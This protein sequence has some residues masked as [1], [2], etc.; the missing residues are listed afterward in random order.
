MIPD[1]IGPYSIER[2][3]GAGGMGTVY[4]GKRDGDGLVAAIKVLPAS[5]A[6]EEGFVARF[7]REI[8]AL[9]KLKNPHVVELYESGVH[10]ETYYYSMEYV[11]GETLTKIL[12]REGRLKWEQVVDYGVQIC[13]ALKA[14]HDAGIV[15][16]DLKPSNLM[17][18]QE[19]QIK[20]MDFGVAYFFAATKLTATRASIGTAEFMSPEQASGSRVTKQSDL[21]SLGAV[22]YAMVTGRP[23]FDGKSSLD[24]MRKHQ[25]ALF[26]H[27][28]KV[29]PE[30]PH[31]LDAVIVQCL[32][33][34]PEK[35]YPDAYVLSLRLAEIPRKMELSRQDVT[36]VGAGSG[37]GEAA[38][39]VH[40]QPAEQLGGGTLMRDLMKAEIEHMHEK[41]PLQKVLDNTFVLVTILV[42]LV[43]GT[44]YFL[45][46]RGQSADHLLNRGL[47]L[48]S[49]GTSQWSK[50]GEQYLEPWLAENPEAAPEQIAKAETALKTI[51]AYQFRKNF[52]F[53]RPSLRLDAPQNEWE[54]LL[55]EAQVAYLQQ[56]EKEATQLLRFLLVVLGDEERTA[57]GQYR[58]ATEQALEQLEQH[59]SADDG[60]AEFRAELEGRIQQ[61]I[62]EDDL[63]QIEI[64][65][66]VYRDK[67]GGELTIEQL[68]DSAMAKTIPTNDEAN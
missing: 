23:P 13:K 28:R 32:E 31:W 26:D 54:R 40:G 19:G 65:F 36:A 30:T 51:S 45:Y 67:Y 10:E 14:A 16:R 8:E 63:S 57:E 34:D 3:I 39:A 29:V 1:R 17:V 22:L 53:N 46:Q 11:E 50:A 49:K 41:S 60:I 66:E 59:L 15:H 64:V 68:T 48:Y 27:P 20:L 52:R 35:R 38:T 58:L 6:R 24:V 25:T 4:V 37:T 61:L 2:K 42:L 43:G 56:D 33:K 44:G 55:R 9:K 21:Y 7:G 12:M 5:L 62:R 18:N 47:E